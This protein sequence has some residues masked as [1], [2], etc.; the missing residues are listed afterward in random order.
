RF[1]IQL[2]TFYGNSN[3]DLALWAKVFQKT[4]CVKPIMVVKTTVFMY[5]HNNHTIPSTNSVNSRFIFFPLFTTDRY[6]ISKINTPLFALY[7]LLLDSWPLPYRLL[8]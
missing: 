2:I 7:A 8:S 5:Y 1:S 3:H 6:S 4:I